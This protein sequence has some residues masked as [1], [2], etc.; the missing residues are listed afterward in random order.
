MYGNTVCSV[1]SC[2]LSSFVLLSCL[3]VTIVIV[4]HCGQVGF[5]LNPAHDQIFM[6]HNARQST[7]PC[8]AS[9]DSSAS[10]DTS[11]SSASS[12]TSDS[13]ASSV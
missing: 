5:I 7:A 11:D 3:S 6:L 10:S 8:S 13:S 4:S 12:D 9:S 2:T 1:R